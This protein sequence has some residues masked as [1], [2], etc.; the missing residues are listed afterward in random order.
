MKLLFYCSYSKNASM[1]R[2]CF[3]V[4]KHILSGFGVDCTARDA[5]MIKI[6]GVPTKSRK[7]HS[8]QCCA[9]PV[10]VHVSSL[11]IHRS[12]M[13][14]PHKTSIQYAI[15]FATKVCFPVLNGSEVLVQLML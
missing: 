11:C 12:S 15:E 8:S 14:K 3:C 10:S 9:R 7:L 5:V 13:T 1:M 4:G 2:W 6:T